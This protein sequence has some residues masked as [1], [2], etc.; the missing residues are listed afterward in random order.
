MFI[1]D[2]GEKRIDN[3]FIKVVEIGTSVEVGKD[4]TAPYTSNLNK[5]GN[6]SWPIYASTELDSE[7]TTDPSCTYVGKLEVGKSPGKTQEENIA[8]VFFVFGD[9]ELKVSVKILKTGEVVSSVFDC[10]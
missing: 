10:L 4:I 8:Q 5:T 2:Y 7:F 6:S 9:T 1:N 3:C